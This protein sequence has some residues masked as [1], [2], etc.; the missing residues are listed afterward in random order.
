MSTVTILTPTYNRAG[1]LPKLYESLLRQTNPD[2]DWLVVDDGSGD[3]TPGLIRRYMEEKKIRISYERQQNAG[4]HTALNRGIA[5][6]ESELTFIVDSDDYLPEDAVDTILAFHGKYKKTPN[7]C[8]YSFL[9][10]HSDGRVNTAYFPEDE[11]KDTYLHVRINGNIGGDKA[12]V[13]YTEILKKYPFPVFE[14]EKYMPEDAVCMQMS[15]PY[16]MVHINKNVY[17]CDYLEDG[18]TNTGRKMK[19]HSP[20]GMVLRSKI[21]LENRETCLKVRVKMMVLYIIYGHFA[22]Y[23]RKQLFAQI[24]DKLLFIACFLPAFVLYQRWN[25]N[26]WE[27]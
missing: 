14:G 18:L 4:K 19:I 16:Q 17:I 27:Q 5:M 12:E 13:F 21:Y 26:Y 15:G 2:F 25:R 24:T 20:K 7:L 6:I 1:F 3:A 23:E 11:K 10:C 8:G 22:G 9:R